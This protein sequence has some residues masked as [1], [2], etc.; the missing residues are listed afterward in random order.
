MKKEDV[1]D[2]IKYLAIVIGLLMMLWR[3][4]SW[5]T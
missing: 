4:F 5:L 1:F 3:A 2:I